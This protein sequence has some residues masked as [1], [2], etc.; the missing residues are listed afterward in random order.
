MLPE[1]EGYERLDSFTSEQLEKYRMMLLEKTKPQTEFIRRHVP[2]APLNVVEIGSGNGRLLISLGLAGLLNSG[3]GYDIS[4]SRTQFANRWATDMD[5]YLN[6]GISFVQRDIVTAPPSPQKDLAICITGCFQYFYSIAP[7]APRNVLRWMNCAKYKLFELYKRPPMG[8]TWKKLPEGD[9]WAYI[10]DE[11]VDNSDWVEHTKVFID[12]NGKEDV[13][14]EN[15]GYYTMSGFLGNLERAG[16]RDLH[17]A[18]E[19]D[20]SMVIL[21]S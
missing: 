5:Q 4:L 1:Y 13:R 9:R 6:A 15:L 3:V 21:A 11:Y 7:E 18:K 17:W 19:N 8:R 14:R 12:R 16:Y 2:N 20:E 10:L